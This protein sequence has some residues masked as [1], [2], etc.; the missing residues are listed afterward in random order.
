MLVFSKLDKSGR[1]E[2][3][4]IKKLFDCFL[5]AM[6]WGDTRYSRNS[7]KIFVNSSNKKIIPAVFYLGPGMGVQLRRLKTFQSL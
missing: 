2:K 5:L 4:N 7:D 3:L 6:G 1:G